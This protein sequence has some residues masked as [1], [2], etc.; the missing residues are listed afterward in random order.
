MS[1]GDPIGI[2]ESIIR[3]DKT[4]VLDY[5]R[6]FKKESMK[7]GA[8]INLVLD[9]QLFNQGKRWSQDSG[10]VWKF[11]SLMNAIP[12]VA[13]ILLP[14]IRG[15]RREKFQNRIQLMKTMDPCLVSFFGTSTV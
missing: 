1:G 2:L 12:S 6:P 15:E 4:M 14:N 7:G 13:H 11:F 9:T 5:H 3:R 10:I 8:T